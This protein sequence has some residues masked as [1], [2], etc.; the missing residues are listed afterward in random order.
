MLLE[1]FSVLQ[2]SF[3]VIPVPTPSPLWVVSQHNTI[4]VGARLS[5]GCRQDANS[6]SG[7]PLSGAILSLS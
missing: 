5:I 7:L 6:I 1:F 3:R 4:F 2:L